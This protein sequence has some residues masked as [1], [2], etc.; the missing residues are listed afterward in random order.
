MC[1]R[2]GRLS[3]IDLSFCSSGITTTTTWNIQNDLCG[4]DHFP[5][6]IQWLSK[7]Q[8]SHRTPKKWM[9]KKAD[10]DFFTKL[11]K[12][13]THLHSE[14]INEELDVFNSALV[15]AALTTI[16]QSS[17][18]PAKIPI[19]WW[20]TDI[21]IAIRERKLALRTYKKE[22]SLNSFIEFK[23]RRAIA[24]KQIREAKENSWQ[25]FMQSI[26]CNST[27]E[28]I[29]NSIKKITRKNSQNICS[30]LNVDNQIT[31]DPRD[32][33]E[34]FANNFASVSATSNYRQTFKEYKLEQDNLNLN[35][36]SD[37][38]EESTWN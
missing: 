9:T 28:Y 1:L 15:N 22:N 18:N 11:T 13:D 34:K 30:Y 23:K 17:E 27:T 7:L 6:I 14:D 24:R 32:I 31:T 21:K 26:N 5:I 20:N 16:P 37:N 3:A 8:R 38:R 33:A 2:S 35:L 25:C 4:S 19:P 36:D 12:M 10:W 29:W